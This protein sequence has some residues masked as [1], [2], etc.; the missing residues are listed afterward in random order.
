M[1]YRVTRVSA[2]F[3]PFVE[4]TE[5]HALAIHLRGFYPDAYG[6]KT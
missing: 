5:V 6:P 2:C 4:I 3:V 1:L